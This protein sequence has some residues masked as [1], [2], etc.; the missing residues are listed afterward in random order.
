MAISD[1]LS[2]LLASPSPDNAVTKTA[3]GDID[4]IRNR[5]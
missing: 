4:P 1:L 2:D 3:D 5:G